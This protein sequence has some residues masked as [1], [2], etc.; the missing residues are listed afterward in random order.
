MSASVL[1]ADLFESISDVGPS[2]EAMAEGAV[3]LRGFVR[4]VEADLLADLRDIG[5]LATW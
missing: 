4:P 1:T 3:L 2:H 5:E